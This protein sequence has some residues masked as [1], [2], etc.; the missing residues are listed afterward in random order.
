MSEEELKEKF[1]EWHL[2]CNGGKNGNAWKKTTDVVK[3]G[4][5]VVAAALL[6][7]LLISRVFDNVAKTVEEF[8]VVKSKVERMEPMVEEMYKVIVVD[9][10]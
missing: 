6:G 9:Q 7:R 5:I 2:Q 10:K 1:Q 8:P 4:A 3:I